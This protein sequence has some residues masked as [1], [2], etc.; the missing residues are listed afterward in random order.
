MKNLVLMFSIGLILIACK[1]TEKP[2]FIGV[3]SIKIRNIS[4]REFTILANLKFEN[5]NDLGGTLQA[6][7][8]HVF[9]DSIDVA[10]VE[11]EIFNVPKRKEFELPLIVKI[12]F[13]K[14]YKNSKQSLLE[15]VL[16]VVTNKK[17]II[18]YKGF[19]DYKLLGFH[20]S[21]PLDYK[22]E[23]TLKES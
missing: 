8:I 17:I 14:I 6:K 19:V 16:N 5:K 1:V 3:N 21:Y 18:S 11:T 9:I 13:D 22:Q 7:D 10:K 20:Y 12:P 4:N 15:S 23:L 2:E